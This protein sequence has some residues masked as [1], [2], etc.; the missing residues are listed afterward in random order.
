MPHTGDSQNKQEIDRAM[1]AGMILLK[2]EF[3]K[4]EKAGIAIKPTYK[5]F[6]QLIGRSVMLISIYYL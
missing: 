5:L 3:K 6:S 4:C 2:Q 1:L